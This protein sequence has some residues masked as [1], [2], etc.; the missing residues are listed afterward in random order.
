M[1]GWMMVL[2]GKRPHTLHI[3][4]LGREGETGETLM[5]DLWYFQAENGV[6]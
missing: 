5:L 3:W 1:D 6:C 4:R 2:K